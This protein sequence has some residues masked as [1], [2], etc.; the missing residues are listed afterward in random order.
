MQI[1]ES[2]ARTRS[3]SVFEVDLSAGEVRKH[4][5]RI[6]LQDQ[7][8][9]ILLH[10]IERQGKLVTREELRK[11]LWSDHTFVDFDRNLN[12]A[13]AKLRSALG[14]S[15]ECPRFIET[16]PRHGYRFLLPIVPGQN[17][18]AHHPATV[19]EEHNAGAIPSRLPVAIP[20]A[21]EIE[22]PARL[23]Y[24][25]T[26][27]WSFSL[28][29][30][31]LVT[32]FALA[33]VVSLR[34]KPFAIFGTPTNSVNFRPSVAVLGFR[35]LSGDPH[36]NWLSTAFSDWLA[37][38][39]SAGGQ[40]RTVSSES[41]ARM[42]I[43]LVLPDLERPG[44]ESLAR[45]RK[46]LGT[47]LVV[48]GSYATLGSDR[49]GQMRLDLR[50]L[51]TRSGEVLY[52][53]SQTGTQEKIFDLVSRAGDDLRRKLGVRDVTRE[54]ALEVSLTLPGNAEADR[55][56]AEGLSK[57]RVF[58]AQG[59]Q[60]SL[61]KAI[62]VEPNYAL[63]HAAL[64]STWA[65]LGYNRNAAGEAKKAF[66]LS[67]GLSRADRLLVEG[68][69][70][71]LSNDW[72]KA[73]ETY[74]ALFKFFPDNPDYG[75]ELVNAQIN[76]NKWKDAL[77]TIVALRALPS[78]LR[79]DPRLDLAEG[80]AAMDLGDMKKAEAVLN[81][82][83]EKARAAGA[84]LLLA[85]AQ[86][87]KVWL[88]ESLGRLDE[89]DAAVQEADNLYIAAHDRKGLSEAETLEA[90]KLEYLGNYGDAR[91]KYEESLA[92]VSETGNQRGIAAGYDNLGDIQLF[93]GN[94]DQAKTSYQHALAI[95]QM[96]K[97]D[98]G[99]A[100][101]KIAL[102][103]V[104]LAQGQLDQAKEMY[105]DS[106]TICHA[107]GNWLREAAALHG[108]GQVLR[109]EG[110]PEEA[111]QAESQ[112]REMFKAA[113]DVRDEAQTE[114]SL[115]ELMLDKGENGRAVTPAQ[116]AADLLARAKAMREGAMADVVLSRVWLAEGKT[117]QAKQSVARAVE[118]AA[119]SHDE[120]VSV[121]AALTQARIETIA[122][123]P[124]QRPQIVK[125]LNAL[126]EE[127]R[128]KGYRYASMETRLLLGQIEMSSSAGRNGLLRV[129][130]LQKEASKGGF[131]LV[132]QEAD[133]VLQRT[134]SIAR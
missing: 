75:L 17:G 82:A 133:T 28:L 43:E 42:K 55:L 16:V 39:L 9:R 4:G 100:L 123:D 117:E 35:N 102:G 32:V 119:R 88:L 61:S 50:L 57:L 64:A 38:E 59:A 124:A 101:A 90:I 56:Y 18:E 116:E 105:A 14:D 83:G 36:E 69:Y 132:S 48:T 110:S 45:I 130:E 12:K 108:L 78:P 31:V 72:E 24:S 122:G 98:N 11:D 15:A 79:D 66:D 84:S 26:E 13:I 30:A 87:D 51:D 20:V 99:V 60:N 85:K 71:E 93:L 95:Y 118:F 33:V 10:L 74:S 106:R 27:G 96:L 68:R 3:F 73:I 25:L 91:K 81:G 70:H 104:F 52:A 49:D 134:N 128:A 129:K 58:D 120:E 34:T 107:N 6:K 89:V 112:A 23:F 125:R 80:K 40:L 62:A 65:D 86:L 77:D 46:N 126:E 63:L 7:P 8:F 121:S 127:V 111:W 37:T 67:G 97:D 53:S 2:S 41:I 76:A 94:V 47:D 92:V 54:E 113:G 29:M 44:H 131:R 109:I 114:L 5:V 21:H 115:A 103:D 1:T 22:R 19:D